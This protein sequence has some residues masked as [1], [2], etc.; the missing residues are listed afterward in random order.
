MSKLFKLPPIYAM[1]CELNRL[2]LMFMDCAREMKRQGTFHH[3]TKSV[4]VWF[5][6]N[7]T[8]RLGESEIAHQKHVIKEALERRLR[9]FGSEQRLVGRVIYKT[10]ISQDKT[11]IGFLTDIG[12]LAFRTDALR[13]AC[14]IEH[15][16]GIEAL[17]CAR[18]VSVEDAELRPGEWA[19]DGDFIDFYALK[20][21][22][23]A[24]RF[25]LEYRN[26]SEEGRYG[27]AL[28]PVEVDDLDGDDFKDLLADF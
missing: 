8:I 17:D 26:S 13:G 11:E 7:E 3:L 19:D 10:R 15:V 20:I 4:R 22:T 23:D 24:G 16:E 27:G 12:P 14:W 5:D 28:I 21:V 1:R 9:Y 2:E 25:Q 6:Q 18:V